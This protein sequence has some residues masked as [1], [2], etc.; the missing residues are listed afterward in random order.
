METY[1]D[2]EQLLNLLE[3][4]QTEN[5][6]LHQQV[7][8]LKKQQTSPNSSQVQEMVSLIAQQKKR[9]AEQSE[10]IEKLNESDLIVKENEK[11]KK[12]NSSLQESVRSTKLHSEITVQACK[13]EYDSKMKKLK[14]QKEKADNDTRVA[15]ELLKGAQE[16]INAKAYELNLETEMRLK[17]E[18]NNQIYAF[19]SVLIGLLLYGLLTT[20]FT[21]VRSNVFRSD[22]KAFFV[23]VWQIIC[24]CETNVIELGQVVSQL[25]NKIPLPIIS[26]IIHYLLLIAL[27]G[28]ITVVLV[29]LVIKELKK[30]YKAY[31]DNY[32]DVKSLTEVLI[33]LAV[34]VYFAEPIRSVLPINLILLVI[35]AHGI[36]ISVRFAR[37]NFS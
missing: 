28:G 27:I 10:L 18:Y 11:L 25:G 16:R 21:A 19:Y 1:S 3:E 15:Q 31:K 33:S 24:V 37:D 29:F 2:E 14:E 8:L 7:D 36:Y 32:A 23:V 12:E 17:S 26:T 30:L 4:L 5:E 20:V 6:Q 34:A 9:I 35:I 13:K 22:F